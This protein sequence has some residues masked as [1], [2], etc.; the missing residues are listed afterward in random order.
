[1]TANCAATTSASP[2]PSTSPALQLLPNTYNGN[3]ASAAIGNACEYSPAPTG[4]EFPGTY[5][6]GIGTAT[7]ECAS[8]DSSDK[9][10]TV[11]LDALTPETLSVKMIGT[12]LEAIFVGV[13]LP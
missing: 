5:L 12:G 7:V 9:S 3:T 2:D 1:V 4:T 11:M 6:T 10:G 8:T 13:L